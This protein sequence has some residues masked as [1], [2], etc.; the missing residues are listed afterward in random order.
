MREVAYCLKFTNRYNS[1]EDHGDG[2]L[3]TYIVT[4]TLRQET[5]DNAARSHHVFVQKKI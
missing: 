4:F 1:S 5:M 3:A 2:K